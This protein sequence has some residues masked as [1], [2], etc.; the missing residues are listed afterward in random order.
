MGLSRSKRGN[1]NHFHR[2]ENYQYYKERR[3]ITDGLWGLSRKKTEET[4]QRKKLG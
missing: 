4:E 2:V 1:N 3:I